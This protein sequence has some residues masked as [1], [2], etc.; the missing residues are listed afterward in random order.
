MRDAAACAARGTR[1]F[2][3]GTIVHFNGDDRDIHIAGRALAALATPSRGV[4]AAMFSYRLFKVCG[5]PIEVLYDKH[6]HGGDRAEHVRARHHSFRLG[7]S[8]TPRHAEFLLRLCTQE[9]RFR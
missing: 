7:S 4:G 5:S 3:D 6:A 2:T 1:A 9:L 8:I